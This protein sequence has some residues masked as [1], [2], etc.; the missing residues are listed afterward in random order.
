MPICEE[1]ILRSSLV[2]HASILVL[3]QA[4]HH[5][6]IIYFIVRAYLLS[7]MDWVRKENQGSCF[8]T[9]GKGVVTSLDDGRLWK[10]WVCI[11]CV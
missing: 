8:R 4:R 3:V 2:F 10:E 9:L 11:H 5:S 1:A 6:Q 7:G